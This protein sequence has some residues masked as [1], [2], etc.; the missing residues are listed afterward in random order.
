[1]SFH[2]KTCSKWTNVIFLFQFDGTRWLGPPSSVSE[3]FHRYFNNSEVFHRYFN[4]SKLLWTQH[5]FPTSEHTKTP[6]F[7]RLPFRRDT[8]LSRVDLLIHGFY[9]QSFKPRNKPYHFKSLLYFPSSV[10]ARPIHAFRLQ[11]AA[12]DCRAVDN[13]LGSTQHLGPLS[14]LHEVPTSS[15]WIYDTAFF[16]DGGHNEIRDSWWIMFINSFSRNTFHAF[17]CA[18]VHPPGVDS[19]TRRWARRRL[20]RLGALEVLGAMGAEVEV[21]TESLGWTENNLVKHEPGKWFGY[22]YM[23]FGFHVNGGVDQQQMVISFWITRVL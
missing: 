14:Q 18:K 16:E 2:Q 9:N 22:S 8:C 11:Y 6:K 5:G 12:Q 20:R 7:S 17:W 10:E 23:L 1:M 19:S 21:A 13:P 3:V 4:N 15:S